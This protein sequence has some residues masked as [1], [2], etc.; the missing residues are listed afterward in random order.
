VE[1]D[2][3]PPTIWYDVCFEKMNDTRL[4]VYSLHKQG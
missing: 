3:L 4:M 2:I 1:L